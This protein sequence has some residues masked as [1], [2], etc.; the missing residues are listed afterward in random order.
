MQD[1]QTLPRSEVGTMKRTAVG[2][3][4]S[5]TEHREEFLNRLNEKIREAI[6]SSTLDQNN[7]QFGNR[8]THKGIY[9]VTS[10]FK[11]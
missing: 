2:V 7:V 9:L 6:F 11:F 8:C 3:E 5:A 1:M 10:T 4:P